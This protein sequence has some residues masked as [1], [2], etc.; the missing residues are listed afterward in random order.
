MCVNII[1]LPNGP[2][3]ISHGPTFSFRLVDSP[4]TSAEYVATY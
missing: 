1:Y 3:V 2:G 4:A